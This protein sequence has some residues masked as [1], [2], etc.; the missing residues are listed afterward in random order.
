MPPPLALTLSI[1]FS[2]AL[3]IYDRRRGS[4]VSRGLWVPFVWFFILGSRSLSLWLNLGGTNARA[5]AEDLMEGSPTDRNL[6]IALIVLAVL[7]LIKRRASIVDIVK[8][9]PWLVLFFCYT[10]LSLLW[11]D[12]PAI[13]SRRWIKSFG[14]PLMALIVLT[15]VEP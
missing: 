5:R 7:V 1:V 8:K 11:S 14:D 6:F 9:N 2:L 10:G 3:F 13:A 12:F 15:E 4:R